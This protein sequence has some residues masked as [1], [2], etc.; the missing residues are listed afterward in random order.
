LFICHGDKILNNEDFKKSKIIIIGH[1]H[2]SIGLQEGNRVEKY[3][4]FLKGKF[5]DKTLIVMPS[6]NQLTEGTDVLTERLLSPYL[7]EKNGCKNINT[8]E[9]WIVEQNEVF[10]FGKLKGLRKE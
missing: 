1:E 9:T 4:C 3:K 5:K 8:F 10:H 7:K 2:P 6:M